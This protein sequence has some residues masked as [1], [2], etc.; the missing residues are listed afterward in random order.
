MTCVEFQELAA[1]FALDALEP[2]ERVACEQHLADSAMHQGCREALRDAEDAAA[3]PGMAMPPARA[4]AD[5]WKG[6]EAKLSPVVAA[7]PVAPRRKLALPI[8]K[9]A[10]WIVAAAAVIVAIV[11][12]AARGTTHVEKAAPS[13]DQMASLLASPDAKVVTL[14]PQGAGMHGAVVAVVSASLAQAIVMGSDLTVAKAGKDYELWVIR[15]DKKIAAGLVKPDATGHVMMPIGKELMGGGADMLAVT[16]E[17]AGGGTAPRGP[18]IMAG[19][20]PQSR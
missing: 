2:A 8:A 20:V 5:L 3:I 9:I 14:A 18:I 17:P 4:R 1:A 19:A 11:V 10:P 12:S 15:G 6:I 13:A 16:L 7:A